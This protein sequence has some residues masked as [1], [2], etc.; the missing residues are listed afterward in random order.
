MQHDAV[1]QTTRRSKRNHFRFNGVKKE[2]LL[3]SFLK[4]QNHC[5]RNK[6]GSKQQLM[7]KSS[8]ERQEKIHL[9]TP[10]E[11]A[12]CKAKNESAIH[13]HESAI[14]FFESAFRFG[15][16]AIGGGWV[17]S[18]GRIVLGRCLRKGFK[19]ACIGIGLRPSCRFFR[20]FAQNRMQ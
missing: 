2:I 19:M 8:F 3:F 6:S 13:F 11:T 18:V 20:T 17:W 14:H 7:R 15:E 5:R 4:H 1:I 10:E 16:S 9:A 12:S